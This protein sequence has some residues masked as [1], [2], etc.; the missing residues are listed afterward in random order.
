MGEKV[1]GQIAKIST[2]ADQCVRVV[3]DIPN[4]VAPADIIKWLNSTVEMIRQAE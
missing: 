4:E 2:T 3:V 1:K